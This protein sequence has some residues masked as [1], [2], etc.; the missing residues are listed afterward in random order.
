[1]LRFEFIVLAGDDPQLLDVLPALFAVGIREDVRLEIR[2]VDDG[3]KQI[4]EG[5]SFREGYELVD[6]AEETQKGAGG[7]FLE[8]VRAHIRSPGG[9]RRVRRVAF[10]VGD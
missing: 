10:V 3:V 9:S 6:E 1:M 4:G 8:G 2:R 5:G 7:S